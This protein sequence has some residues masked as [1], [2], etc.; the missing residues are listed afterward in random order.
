MLGSLGPGLQWCPATQY[1]T[2]LGTYTETFG[3][4]GLLGSMGF[5]RLA[6]ATG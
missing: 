4:K 2:A 5:W 1:H 6:K 3:G